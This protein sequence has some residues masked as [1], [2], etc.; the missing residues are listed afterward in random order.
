MV[1][2]FIRDLDKLEPQEYT[3]ISSLFQVSFPNSVGL[4]GL[5]KDFIHVGFSLFFAKTDN[6]VSF[7]TL[8]LAKR[9]TLYLYYVC[10]CPESRGSGVFKRAFKELK[11]IYL[12]KGFTTFGLD[13][14]EEENV[15]PGMTQAK[16]IQIFN[17][18]G[19][20]IV[21]KKNPNPF[22]Q[23]TGDLHTYVSLKEGQARLLSRTGNIYSVLMNGVQK[24]VVL[25]DILG[26]VEDMKSSEP[27][28]C[29]MLTNPIVKKGGSRRHRVRGRKTRRN[30]C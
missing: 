24:S 4:D 17:R 21:P 12:K 23:N 13:A 25:S 1:K 28:L 15:P 27:D 16:R 7:V 26:C 3:D 2:Y 20:H 11:S 6:K 18:L 5:V 8:I 9:P 30:L 14:S 19:F 29:P 10:V 22:K